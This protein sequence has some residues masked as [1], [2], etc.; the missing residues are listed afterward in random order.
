MP[1]GKPKTSRHIRQFTP[2][3]ADKKRRQEAFVERLF[4]ERPASVEELSAIAKS[5][6]IKLSTARRIALGA[7]YSLLGRVLSK[8][9]VESLTS[10][11]VAQMQRG[12]KLFFQYRGRLL[13]LAQPLL[14]A[15]A[16]MELVYDRVMDSV[17][18]GSL[19][20]DPNNPQGESFKAWVYRGIDHGI[21]NAK[22]D[23]LALQRKRRRTRSMEAPRFPGQM[24]DSDL[25]QTLESW[26]ARPLEILSTREESRLA[27]LRLRDAFR[28]L[29]AREQEIIARRFGLAG[30]PES[31]EHIGKK[32]GVGKE[33]IRQLEQRALQKLR[34]ILE[35]PQA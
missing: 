25:R 30:E 10:R 12:L 28:K 32:L 22:S 21:R 4:S 24:R 13:S 35:E 23:F 3:I 18:R 27:S 5:M 2:K 19:L 33:W 6:A 16:S 29:P 15:G 26:V 7:G 20:Y 9:K 14:R 34:T 8:I 17:I 31:L 11:Q 1:A